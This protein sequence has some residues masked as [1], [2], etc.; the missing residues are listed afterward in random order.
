[1]SQITSGFRSVLSKPLVYDFFQYLLGAKQWRQ[2]FINQFVLPEPNNR[3]LDI[4]CGTAKILKHLPSSISYYGFDADPKYIYAAKKE[5]GN[6]G[7]FICANIK[8]AKFD[9]LKSF[10]I[11]LAIGVLHH[12]SDSE[13]RSLVKLAHKKLKIGGR[14][15]TADPCL[16][17]KQNPLARYLILNDRGQNVRS[18]K[19]YHIL[20]KNIFSY[21]KGTIL[22]RNWIPYTHWLMECKK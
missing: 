12:L 4:G 14:L 3:I 19:N 17:A 2:N 16:T 20:T 18:S 15:I 8:E 22:H 21:S 5:F 7:K 13:A 10:D 1:M 6:K 11:V 9:N